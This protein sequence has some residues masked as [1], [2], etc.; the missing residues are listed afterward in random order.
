MSYATVTDMIDRFGLTEMIRLSEKE[1]RTATV[2]NAA[3]IEVALADGGALI[4]DYL[5]KRY[6]VPV[7]T[8]PSSLT[9]ANCVLARYDLAQGERTD[10][11]EEQRLARKEVIRWLEGLASGAVQIDAQAAGQGLGGG[12]SGARSS[13]RGQPF[14]DDNLAGW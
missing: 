10:P 4:D 2:V 11:T 3:K 1:D 12:A 6:L 9:R 14:S 13:D 5:R 7:A 8:P